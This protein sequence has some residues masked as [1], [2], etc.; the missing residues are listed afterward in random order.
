MLDTDGY[1]IP[2]HTQLAL[3]AY[4]EEG[5]I[6]GGFLTAILC[7]DL[8]GAVA[9]ADALNLSCMGDICKFIY[10]RLPQGAWGSAE[11]MRDYV[12][13]KHAEQRGVDS[14]D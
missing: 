7:N 11:I 10:N 3:S 6:P 5:I 4:V 1:N 13:R 8:F 14:Q 2:G 9:R 12:A